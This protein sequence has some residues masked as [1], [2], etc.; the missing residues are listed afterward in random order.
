MLEMQNWGS[1]RLSYPLKVKWHII[2]L[3][4]KQELPDSKA[5]AFSSTMQF[6]LVEKKS[7]LERAL[8]F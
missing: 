8:A 5:P 2:K 3:G 1:E 7:T 4:L 6:S